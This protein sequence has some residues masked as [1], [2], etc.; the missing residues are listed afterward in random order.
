[1][2]LYFVAY[3]SHVFTLIYASGNYCAMAGCVFL[4]MR[5]ITND[6]F[7][8][9]HSDWSRQDSEMEQ[10]LDGR[11]SRPSPRAGGAIHPVLLGRV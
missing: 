6:D 9:E 11:C 3:R 2:K 10:V 7:T 8:A 5:T 4:T 1:M